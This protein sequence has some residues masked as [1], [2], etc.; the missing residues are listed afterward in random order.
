MT[1]KYTFDY[2]RIYVEKEEIVY[3]CVPFK[4]TTLHIPLIDIILAVENMRIKKK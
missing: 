1:D 3:V 2:G 4:D